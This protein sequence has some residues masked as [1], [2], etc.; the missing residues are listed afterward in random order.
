MSNKELRVLNPSRSG[1]VELYV[2]ADD[3]RGDGSVFTF[4]T[5]APD[6]PYDRGSTSLDLEGLKKVRDWCDA[7][8]REA[9]PTSVN[10]KS[11]H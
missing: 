9:Q 11:E 7:R 6:D 10:T 3:W 2:S 1:V 4:F 8:I 5:A